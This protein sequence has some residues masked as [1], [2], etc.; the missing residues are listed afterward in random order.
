MRLFPET[1]GRRW[2]QL[3]MILSMLTGNV[4]RA[5]F[6]RA[7]TDLGGPFLTMLHRVEK[8]SPDSTDRSTTSWALAWRLVALC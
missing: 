1:R 5:S 2:A 3:V 4:F 8:S 6:R 7:E